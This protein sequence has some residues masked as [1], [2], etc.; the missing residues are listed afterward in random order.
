LRCGFTL[1]IRDEC[2]GPC[3]CNHVPIEAYEHV[4]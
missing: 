4:G 1:C 3:P 2:V